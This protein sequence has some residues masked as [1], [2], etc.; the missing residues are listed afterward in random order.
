MFQ[1][2]ALHLALAASAALTMSAGA[3][4]D[5][6]SGAADSDATITTR[7]KSPAPSPAVC[8]GDLNGDRRVDVLDL[9]EVILGWG[10]CPH[11]A[12]P[13]GDT[14]NEGD[15]GSGG[16]VMDQQPPDDDSDSDAGLN[17]PGGKD[18]GGLSPDNSGG[19][20]ADDDDLGQE[21]PCQGDINGDGYVDVQDMIEV[22]TNFGTSCP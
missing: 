7:D 6:P 3:R 11:D 21:A 13:A 1:S 17:E 4:S 20:A 15:A 14:F 16:P 10:T 19:P 2:H 18:S 9:I 8:Q 12:L 22:L 5:S